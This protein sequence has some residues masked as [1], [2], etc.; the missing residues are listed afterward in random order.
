MRKL[1]IKTSPTCNVW[2][3][4]D[5]HLKHQGPKGGT[6][7]WQSRGYKDPQ[8]MTQMIINKVNELV[9]P[10][11][12]LFYMG[13]W[14]LN[15]NE[16]EFEN[17]LVQINCRNIMLLW[18]NHNN[19]VQRV[20]ERE[21]AKVAS[22]ING[23]IRWYDP[24]DKEH[25]FRDTSWYGKVEIY[26]FRYKNVVFCGD[27]MEAIIDG[28]YF[29]MFHYPIDVWNEMRH[30]AY[31]LCGHSHYSYPKTRHDCLENKRLDLSWDGHLRP[32]SLK[33]VKAIMD[34]KGMFVLDHHGKT[35]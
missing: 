12:Y 14:C 32:L 20:Y 1:N 9:K 29:C 27:Y 31:M 28:Q 18:G 26:P 22:Q 6:P 2:F 30:D 7:L 3:S 34:K 23:D 5:F 10:D 35:E 4:S 13:D 33:E 16:Y 8:H 19:P 24:S 11:D 17:D 25:K 21:V 15:T